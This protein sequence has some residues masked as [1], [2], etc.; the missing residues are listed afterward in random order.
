M[1]ATCCH[2]FLRVS[3]CWKD[4]VSFLKEEG[5]GRRRKILAHVRQSPHAVRCMRSCS[6]CM[7]LTRHDGAWGGGEGAGFDGEHSSFL[8]VKQCE[9]HS[10][11]A[12]LVVTFGG[13]IYI[14]EE[15]EWPH[16]P[17]SSPQQVPAINF[18]TMWLRPLCHE[19][20]CNFL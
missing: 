12:L 10:C 7:G 4:I 19:Q 13:L 15:L 5:K 1:N 9:K 3:A 17:I 6:P 8:H 2:M 20:I 11:N 16:L 18:L 14:W